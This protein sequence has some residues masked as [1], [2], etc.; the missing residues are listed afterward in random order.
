MLLH[1]RRME[2]HDAGL[3]DRS[4]FVDRD[5]PS[6]TAA[7]LGGDHKL[8]AVKIRR[9]RNYRP[10]THPCNRNLE[11]VCDFAHEFHCWQHTGDLDRR[12]LLH[13]SAAV[14]NGTQ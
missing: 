9:S 12:S 3:G 2:G 14:E 7:A 5:G 1:L 13:P 11:V 10:S 8:A 6:T 4:D